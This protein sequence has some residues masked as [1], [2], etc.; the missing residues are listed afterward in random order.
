MLLKKYFFEK[1]T[2]ATFISNH[3]P[4]NTYFGEYVSPAST[5]LFAT[6]ASERDGNCYPIDQLVVHPQI[7]R[8]LA[9]SIFLV[10]RNKVYVFSQSRLAWILHCLHDVCKLVSI[11]KLCEEIQRCCLRGSLDQNVRNSV[12]AISRRRFMLRL[13]WHILPHF[14]RRSDTFPLRV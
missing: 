13:H 1:R 9:S 2:K 3:C 8:V 7:S 12:A 10:H 11:N 6:H 14:L 4:K 5:L